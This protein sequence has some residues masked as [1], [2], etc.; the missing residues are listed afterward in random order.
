MALGR[1]GPVVLGVDV[2]REAVSQT[3]A[4]GGAAL[5]RD[6]F[7]RLPGEGRWQTALLADGNVGIGG[8]PLAML[9]RAC[10]LVEVQGRTVVELAGPG[11]P[12]GSNWAV[13]RCGGV[14]SAPFRWATI[15]VDDIHALAEE[16]G[17]AE[18]DVHRLGGA[19]LVCGAAVASDARRMM[20]G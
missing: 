16:A 4:R 18:V 8:D 11:V 5:R 7:D 10:E 6:I 20:G 12:P 9:L 17:Y 15:G 1:L 13:L 2:V 3:R 14:R 19:A